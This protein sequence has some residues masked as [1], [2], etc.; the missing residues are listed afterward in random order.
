VEWSVVGWSVVKWGEGL[1]N[2]ASTIIRR[3][4]D[5]MKF[6]AYMA[7]SFITIFWFHFYHCIYGCIFCMLLF[8]FV[9]YIFLLLC[10]CIL[11]FT[12]VLFCVL[13]HCVVLCIVC[14]SMYTVLL[15]PGV[16]PLHLTEYIKRRKIC[17]RL[18]AATTQ[19]NNFPN[20][21]CVNLKFHIFRCGKNA[22]TYGHNYL[23]NN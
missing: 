4:I 20:L 10:V 3:Y 8:N 7:F 6:D 12:Y 17:T 2:R 13:F 16:S 19:K 22:V 15:P 21:D 11:I 1:N 9:N 23:Q 5:H 18:H 14:V